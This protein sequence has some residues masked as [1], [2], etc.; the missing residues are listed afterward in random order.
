MEFKKDYMKNYT[1]NGVVVDLVAIVVTANKLAAAVEVTMFSLF[2]MFFKNTTFCIVKNIINEY[3]ANMI[4]YFVSA[5]SCENLSRKYYNAVFIII[6]LLT[7]RSFDKHA[8][9]M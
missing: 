1:P 2:H 9:T 8:S 3:L 4:L 6:E 5:I 7:V